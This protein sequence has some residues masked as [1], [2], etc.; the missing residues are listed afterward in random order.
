MKTSKPYPIGWKLSGIMLLLSVSLS[1]CSDDE[2]KKT[3][4]DADLIILQEGQR[5]SDVINGGNTQEEEEP[6]GDIVVTDNP[7]ISGQPLFSNPDL[8]SPL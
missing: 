6:D 7:E 3:K 8:L 2:T 4:V 1:G 5:P